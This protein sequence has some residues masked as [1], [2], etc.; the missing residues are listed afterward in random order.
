MWGANVTVR[1]FPV[2]PITELVDERLT[3]GFGSISN[4]PA[5]NVR[6]VL[7]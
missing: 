6:V 4:C 3:S 2:D 7:I 1:L 5:V